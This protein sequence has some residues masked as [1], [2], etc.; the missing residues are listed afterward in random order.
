VITTGLCSVTLRALPVDDVVAIAAGAGLEGIEW[1]ADVHVPP[2]DMAAAAAARAATAAAGL[3]VASYGS[4]Y[5]AGADDPAGFAAVL[6]SARALGAPRIR[7][8]AGDVASADASPA[9]RAAVTVAARDAADRA[10]AANLEVAFEFHGGTLTDE[11]QPALALL[12]AVDRGR[13]GAARVRSYW[14]PP[15]DVPD[16]EA[17]AGLRRLRGHVTAVHV[18]SWWPGSE[19]LRL[20]GRGGMWR[21]AFRWL[22]TTEASVDAL[23]E[24][25]PGDDPALVAGEAR[26]LIELLAEVRRDPLVAEPASGRTEPSST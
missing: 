19:R 20:A 1:G 21:A 2:G 4:Y 17:L 8:W 23:L 9:A 7:V 10:A 13:S 22:M 26:T 6:D 15:Q 14:Q 18:F 3:R 11:A 12:Q 24:F 25:V 5:R 16:D